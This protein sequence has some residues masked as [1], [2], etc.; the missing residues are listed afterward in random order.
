MRVNQRDSSKSI[1]FEQFSQNEIE[2][3]VAH[4]NDTI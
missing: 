1:E 3:T 4:Q 2:N